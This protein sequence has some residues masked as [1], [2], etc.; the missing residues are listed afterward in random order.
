MK[1]YIAELQRERNEDVIDISSSSN[2]SSFIERYEYEEQLEKLRLEIDRLNEL[3]AENKK[4]FSNDLEKVKCENERLKK[5]LI[6]KDEIISDAK[7]MY[8]ALEEQHKNL[9]DSTKK[10]ILHNLELEQRHSV[11]GMCYSCSCS[12]EENE[13]KS[14]SFKVESKLEVEVR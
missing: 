12:E 5:L 1:Q 4:E 3:L 8:L 2:E 14:G 7:K 11:I 10:T 6:E 9:F 13:Q